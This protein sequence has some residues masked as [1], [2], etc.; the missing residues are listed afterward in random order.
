[1]IS[2]E[3]E[4][5]Q[6]AR[7][8]AALTNVKQWGLRQ[9]AERATALDEARRSAFADIQERRGRRGLS[10]REDE[11]L[12]ARRAA[13][14]GVQPYTQGSTATPSPTTTNAWKKTITSEN[15]TEV[16]DKLRAIAEA[17]EST[18]ALS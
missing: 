13:L 16:L 3:P 18:C 14:A 11:I 8:A 12:E 7:R 5:Q 15:T 2:P 1:M 4:Q 9:A 10:A 6:D 17:E